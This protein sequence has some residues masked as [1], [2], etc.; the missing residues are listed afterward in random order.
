MRIAMTSIVALGLAG[1]ATAPIPDITLDAWDF[2]E[3]TLA[4]DDP[5]PVELVPVAEPWPLPGQLMPIEESLGEELPKEAR[6][7]PEPAP[8]PSSPAERI[9]LAN[10]TARMQPHLDGYLNAVQ[11]YPFTPG[12][13]YQLYAAPEQVTDVALQPGEQLISVSAG[14]TVRWIVGDTTSGH[15]DG[16]QAH[17]LVKPIQPGLKTNLVVTTDRRAY[18][19]EL[20]SF[21][22]TYM[23]SISWR[24]P[25][26]ELRRRIA[27]NDRAARAADQVVERELVLDQLRFRYAISGDAPHW[28]PLRAFDDG[29]K[30]YI[31]FPE[32]IDQGEA[33]PLF[34]LGPDGDAQLVNYRVRG[35]Y[36][37][38]DRLF[39]AAELRLGED[40][41]QVV[42]IARADLDARS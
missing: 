8:E 14:D 41:Q 21:R 6:G 4:E 30:V 33:P 42:R 18:H 31:Q 10:E 37:V 24:Y 15:P 40:P 32:R 13:L 7:A 19:L 3:A 9:D 26:D 23:A 22:E 20:T 11:I 28:R 17:I 5:L 27:A 16:D 2:E 1:C 12:A 29:R 34:V 35:A 25:A 36:Y 39:A 38:V